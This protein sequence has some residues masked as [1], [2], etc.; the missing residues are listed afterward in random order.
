MGIYGHYCLGHDPL[1]LFV[2]PVHHTIQRIDTHIDTLLLRA[3]SR[4]QNSALHIHVQIDLATRC[5][6][7]P[8]YIHIWYMQQKPDILWTND[9]IMWTIHSQSIN[10][11]PNQI[12]FK[13]SKS[14]LNQVYYYYSTRHSHFCVCGGGCF[15]GWHGWV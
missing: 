6:V 8:A 14:S 1:V 9:K 2:F 12:S 3:L 5:S 7:S 13:T 10:Q 11:S 4:A 15:G